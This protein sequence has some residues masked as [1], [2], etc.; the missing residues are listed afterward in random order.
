MA[1]GR[2]LSELRGHCRVKII[3]STLTSVGSVG[4]FIMLK[5]CEKPGSRKNVQV[6]NHDKHTVQRIYII[7]RS[8]VCASVFD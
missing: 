7:I 3:G 8:L 4:L 2:T 5:L 1:D 6:Q